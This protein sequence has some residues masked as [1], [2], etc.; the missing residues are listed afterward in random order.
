MKCRL[1]L[2]TLI[3][4]VFSTVLVGCQDLKEIH[5]HAMSVSFDKHKNESGAGA[6]KMANTHQ[7][8]DG[9]SLP[10]DVRAFIL[11][12]MTEAGCNVRQVAFAGPA[13]TQKAGENLWVVTTG[14][15]CYSGA[16]QDPYV[17]QTAF[18][19]D[20]YNQVIW[21][22]YGGTEAD[23]QSA[24]SRFDQN[25]NRRMLQSEELVRLRKKYSVN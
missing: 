23:A 8:D 3:F 20:E 9:A 4:P 13:A 22:G 12:V 11:E 24:K 1:L 18:L 21:W 15:N 2:A 7:L 14:P 5:Q 19:Y 6:V 25:G 17:H 16:S 10:P